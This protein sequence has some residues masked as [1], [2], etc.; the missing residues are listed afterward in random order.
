MMFQGQKKA[1]VTT[2]KSVNQL[3][4]Y[5][6]LIFSR[7][8]KRHIIIPILP[9]G[10][11]MSKSSAMSKALHTIVICI[12]LSNFSIQKNL[13]T[14]DSE[15][16]NTEDLTDQQL[17]VIEARKLK[18]SQGRFQVFSIYLSFHFRILFQKQI[19]KWN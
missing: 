1:F 12:M 19:I 5:F 14:Y 10:T 17:T 6:P 15:A 13:E 11:I 4:T 7:C 8:W 18:G 3:I 9:V 2:Y 16:L